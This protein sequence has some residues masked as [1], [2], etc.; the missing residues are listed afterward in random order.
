M[1]QGC[2]DYAEYLAVIDAHIAAELPKMIN[3]PIDKAV[4][5]PQWGAAPQA[6]S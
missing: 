5:Y 3:Q 2:D 6:Q 4:L 1:C